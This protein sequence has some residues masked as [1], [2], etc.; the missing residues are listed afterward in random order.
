MPAQ[1]VSKA[2][3]SLF[4]TSSETGFKSVYVATKD[5][6]GRLRYIAKIKSGGKLRCLPG[7]RSYDP[8]ETAG[9]VVRWYERTFGPGWREAL[10]ARKRTPWRLWFSRSRGG[11]C[12]RAWLRGRPAEVL[13]ADGELAT[14]PSRADA[15]AALD[16]FVRERTGAGFRR[17]PALWK[18][19]AAIHTE[20]PPIDES[21]EPPPPPPPP[22][23]RHPHADA[24]RIDKHRDG[25][26]TATVFVRGVPVRVPGR[27]ASTPDAVAAVRA[28]AE[29]LTGSPWPCR[30]SLWRYPPATDCGVQVPVPT[31]SIPS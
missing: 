30:Q 23:P 18:T 1:P 20:L 26:R 12:A 22:E 27:F 4:R 7:S 9:C 25:S 13:T 31:V 10:L 24:Y 6:L 17:N 14:F 15:A 8:R 16:A 2:D 28:F 19:G 29:R 3:L 11:W 21:W 5:T